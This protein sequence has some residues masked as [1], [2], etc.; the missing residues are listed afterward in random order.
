MNRGNLAEDPRS[1]LSSSSRYSRNGG[2]KNSLLYVDSSS[3]RKERRAAERRAGNQASTIKGNH[4]S[5]RKKSVGR[6]LADSHMDRLEVGSDGRLFRVKESSESASSMHKQ[7]NVETTAASAHTSTLTSSDSEH[8]NQ[9]AAENTANAAPQIR[10]AITGEIITQ[11]AKPQ[12]SYLTQENPLL[13][14]KSAPAVKETEAANE[15]SAPAVKETD[16]RNAQF[17]PGIRTMLRRFRVPIIVSA[18]TLASAGYGYAAWHYSD[19]FYPGTEFFG[20]PAAELSVYDVKAAVKA[21]VDSYSLQLEARKPFVDSSEQEESAFASKNVIDAEDVEMV[22]CD[23][24]EI[25]DAMK[26]QRSWA[27]PVMM[28]AQLFGERNSAFETSYN[29]DLVPEA[30][31]NLACMQKSNMIKPQNAQVV[32]TDDG[33]RV[34]TEIYG[35]TLDVEKT[36]EAVKKA[37]NDGCTSIDLDALGLY[38][39]PKVNSSDL[40]L[41]SKAMAMNKVLG[42]KILLRF[43]NRTEV[44]NSEVI[45]RFLTKE[46]S[47][48]TLNEEKVRRYVSR[49]AKKYD[50]YQCEREFFTSI[51]T[52]VTLEEG[53]GDYGWLLDQEAVYEQIL[54]AIRSQKKTTITPIF[55]REAYCADADDIGD[56]YVEISLT[57]QM[58]WFYKNGM[59]VVKTPVVTGNPYAGHET[60]SGGVWSLKG[61]MRNQTL[62]GQG[63]ASPV[64][65]WM[66]FNNGVGIHDMQ[67]RAYFGGTIYLGSGSHGCVNTPLSA[68]KL[69]YDQIEEGVPVIVYKDESEEAYAHC[70]DPVDVQSLN[71]QIEDSYGTVEDDGIGSIVAWSRSKAAQAAVSAQQA[72]VQNTTPVT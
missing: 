46:G 1:G 71:A 5:K 28:L 58:M 2:E 33:A 69:I 42:A 44:I 30:V 72:A 15:Q 54:E 62:S 17:A 47:S 45:A 65:Y 11:T 35:T 51:G 38:V 63:Y 32:L 67:S 25:D 37:L 6:G 39:N 49:L 41:A 55:T 13:K 48:Y 24:N 40:S 61:K 12:R 53:I 9:P 20:I 7:G 29:A 26:R 21:K 52:K 23:N 36:E 57:N 68:V 16:E 10:P 31:S 27:W 34:Q 60:P 22:Y 19:R 59:L 43:G 3:L 50:T 14:K 4:N 18:V 56:T 8:T 64:D 70:T 66:P